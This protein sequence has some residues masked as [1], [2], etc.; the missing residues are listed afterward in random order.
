MIVVGLGSL[1]NAGRKKCSANGLESP[2]ETPDVLLIH[3]TT[4]T[5]IAA[6][7]IPLRSPVSD[8][9]HQTHVHVLESR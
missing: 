3:Y 7:F 2:Q 8:V 6:Y 9:A 1:G 4:P 5:L